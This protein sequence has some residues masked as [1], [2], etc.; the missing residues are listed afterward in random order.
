MIELRDI[1]WDN[2]WDVIELAPKVEQAHYIPTTA[3]YM[4]QA[5]VN[6]K[7][8]DEGACLAVYNNNMLVGF[9]KIELVPAGL[10]PFDFDEDA[11]YLDG[12]LIGA[13]FQGKGLGRLALGAIVAFMRNKPFGNAD[14][15]K[16]SCYDENAGA[17]R[18]YEAF[19][20]IGL[21]KFI[22]DKSGRKDLRVYELR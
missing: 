7:A 17:V 1:T 19:G 18:L 10:Y 15:I 21:D 12:F 4:A 3:V 6:L 8:G 20:F 5:W 14:A 22:P 2:L 13:K 9:A 16:L 11:Y